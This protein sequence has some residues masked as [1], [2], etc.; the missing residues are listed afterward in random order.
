[1]RYFLLFLILIHGLIHLLGFTKAFSLAPVEQLQLPIS[2]GSGI[3]WLVASLLFGLTA[4]LQF[5]DSSS[6]ALWA[7]VAIAISQFLIFL[8]WQD[9]KWGTIAN[10]IILVAAVVAFS[11]HIFEQSFRQDVK[12]QLSQAT[13]SAGLLTTS[14]MVHLPTPVKRY[15]H[16]T[17]AVNQPKVHNMVVTFRGRMRGKDEDWFN[18]TSRQFNDFSDPAR[19]FFM[20]ANVKGLPTNGYHAYQGQQA[21]MLIKILSLF[22]VVDLNS[23]ELFRAETVTF[24]NDMCLFAPAAL[25]DP[26]I[27][28]E[29]IDSVSCRATFTNPKTSISAT[30][31]FDEEG[32][33]INFKSRDRKEINVDQYLPFST[34]V[35][36]Y[37]PFGATDQ[38]RLMGD[39]Q[40]VWHYPDGAFP[41]GEF[42][43]VEVRY[44]VEE[45]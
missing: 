12:E 2:K 15:L 8:A 33:L 14:D 26:H 10:L 35:S 20:K 42:H 32:K 13:S 9:A 18:F 38:F 30:L 34:P 11:S 23:E 28:W 3:L 21:S 37:Q 16:Y 44:N 1:M 25:V 5:R 40:A 31:Y 7:F 19:L 36:S 4:I 27:Q 39:G 43:T 24:F 45:L 41:Y 17:G 29:P 6:W 22:P